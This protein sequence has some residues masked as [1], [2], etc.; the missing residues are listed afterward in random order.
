M[1]PSEKSMLL[2]PR[3]DLKIETYRRLASCEAI[4]VL[5]QERFSARVAIRT[6]AGWTDESVDGAAEPL[7]IAS[8]GLRCTLREAY[9]R[10]SLMRAR[11]ASRQR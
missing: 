8:A 5:E 4:L 10:T 7:I 6:A 3:L 1:L 2:R 9:A 11:L